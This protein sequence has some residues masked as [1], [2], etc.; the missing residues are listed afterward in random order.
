MGHADG[1]TAEEEL[2]RQRSIEQAIAEGHDADIPSSI[3]YV[4]NE[5]V[6]QSRR[7]SLASHYNHSPAK[8]TLDSLHHKPE[9][10]LE[11]AVDATA[12]ESDGENAHVP[13][14]SE[15][16]DPNVVWWEG[17][18]DPE[19]P[20]NWPEWRKWLNCT[21]VSVLT[22]LTPLASSIFA[23]GVPQLSQEF[24]VTNGELQ[25]LVVSIYVLGYA[26]G[27]LLIAPLSEIYGRNIVYHI[28]NLGF[29]AFMVACAVAP[30]MD[31]LIGFRFMS[32]FFGSCPVTNGGGSIA[33][34]IVPQ[35]RGVA[36]SLYTLGPIFGPVV[37]PVAGGFL[38]DA[39]GW[40]WCFWIVV[41]VAGFMSIAMMLFMKETYAP[42]ILER[43][44]A[45][46]RKERGN[47][48]LRSKLDA[49]MSA[50]DYFT[51]SIVRPLKLIALSPI[52]QIFAIYLGIVYGYLYLLFTTITTV[53]TDSYNFTSSTAGLA[54]LGLGVGSVIGQVL[55]SWTSDSYSQRRAERE[56]NGMKP[57]YRLFWLPLAAIILPVGFFIYGWTTE[58]KIHWIVPIIAMG[59]VG[60]ANILF[61]MCVTM[62]LIDSFQMYAAS[63]MAANVVV[64][65]VAGA[66]L[67]LAAPKMYDALGLGWGNSLLAFIA[68]AMLP[69][70]FII[71]RYGEYL[72]TRFKVKM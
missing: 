15:D 11:R 14:S 34:M 52:T 61:F 51:R 8:S 32:G 47:E 13:T 49:G 17:D 57:E 62:Y 12:T 5:N 2:Q 35:K 26:F 30:S 60:V 68:V 44:A 54:Y 43:K 27:P 18:D 71:S 6:N 65:S 50:K 59:I 7:Q 39:K 45:K 23:P 20:Y 66:V 21:F 56:G 33:D 22:F 9:V 72:R 24:N 31:S 42:V 37:G 40:R 41:I 29:I 25:T 3:G 28:C 16:D 38:A 63:A 4:V 1:A 58:Y 19:N 69:I 48:L 36:M 70:P 55:F 64:R 53:F 67:P 10:D 46:L